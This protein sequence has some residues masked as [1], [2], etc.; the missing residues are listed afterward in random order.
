MLA[1]M[2]T[3]Y[4]QIALS[5]FFRR[6][7]VEGADSV[8]SAGPVLLV[9]N[10]ANA[11]V[12]PF[13]VMRPLRRRVHLTAKSTLSKSP[14]LRFVA[15]ALDVV[16]FHRRQ[17]RD[18]GANPA[19]N[20]ESLNL[21][22]ER[23]HAG[24][25]VCIFPEGQSHSEPVMRR[26]LSGVGRIALDYLETYPEG[27][28]L[29]IVPVGL[30]YEQKDRY[31]S[32]AWVRYGVPID[33][34]AWS[35]ANPEGGARALT[36]RV[37]GAVRDLQVD[38]DSQNDPTVLNFLA[39]LMEG[40]GRA[41]RQLGVGTPQAQ[42]P[43]RLRSLQRTRR[44]MREFE[45]RR[46][47]VLESRV[48]G[49]RRKLGRLGIAPSEVF[50][51]VHAGRALFF[52]LRE[53]ELFFIGLPIRLW[54]LLNH[55]V[56][57]QIVKSV[58]LSISKDEDQVA[59]N[60]TFLS[61]PI[62]P[63]FYLVQ[64][65]AVSAVAG[66]GIASLY[67]ISLPYSGY[68]AVLH[69]DRSGGAWRRAR[70]FLSFLR[71][72]TL[73]DRLVA[74]GHELL[75]LVRKSEREMARRGEGLVV[76]FREESAEI[77]AITGGKGANLSR[78]TRLGF[79]VPPGK[80]IAS[81]AYETFAASVVGSLG[82]DLAALGLE[83]EARSIQL[84]LKIRTRI[85][86]ETLPDPVVA[87]IEREIM[88]LL[89]LGP[90]AVR[91]SSTQEDLEGAAF[92]GQHDTFLH[93]TTMSAVLD[94]VRRCYASLWEYRA[95]RYRLE[96]GFRLEEASMA[97]V[98]QTMVAAEVAG[99]AFSVHPV[100]GAMDHV[101]VNAAYGLGETVVSGDGEIDQFVVER[102]GGQILE[103]RVA[104]KGTR[105]V[106]SA[107]GGVKSVPVAE[108]QAVAPC[109]EPPQL[110]QI[111][112]LA[113]QAKGPSVSLRILSGRLSEAASTCCSPAR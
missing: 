17:D 35:A 51:R 81:V 96:G 99:V 95:V 25:A 113:V 4:F 50:L 39:A 82:E 100:S 68:V 46:L 52:L 54:G 2:V 55:G 60:A 84:A 109:L 40:E 11:L 18:L 48:V 56:P 77:L 22:R 103:T 110:A 86:D 26:F 31:R 12:D 90:V 45:P 42:L 20:R 106:G 36:Q 73:Q 14:L 3:A 53:L 87:A 64:T 1:R 44:Q 58:T 107:C 83:D 101:L 104:S 98:V 65:L 24:G 57:F 62:F 9:S 63:L 38:F 32:T 94:S 76:D 66:A 8:P 34:V 28:A 16:V 71:S 67:L 93:I 111:V 19:A 88:P 80:V 29:R 85:L 47:A 13:L 78:T 49:Y 5:V 70:T 105:L 23:L 6:I 30:H 7:V 61:L 43:T 79:P 102:Q 72:P 15:W 89:E 59:S 69:R 112:E 27:P 97:V 91:S 37:E 10:H 92:A 74:E 108:A 21:C 41:P 33:V 75:A